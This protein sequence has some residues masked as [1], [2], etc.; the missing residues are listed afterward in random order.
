MRDRQSP[1][2]HRLNLAI[3]ATALI[4][5]I[6]T[7]P[8]RA[9]V[10][11]RLHFSVKNAADEKPLPKA[12]ILL[13]D[14][15]GVRPEVTLTTDDNGSVTSGP[16]D[17]R[18]WNV[19]TN[20]QKPDTFQSDTRSVTVAPDTTTEVEV[21][22][23]PIKEEKIIHIT[24]R[25]NI[26][27]PAQAN[28][29]AQLDQSRVNQFPVLGSN[30]QSLRNELLV[31]PGFVYDSANQAH[32]RGEH[33]STTI[34]L[35][36]FELPDV[37]MG[38]AGA[39]IL[40]EAL[41]N[42]DIMT[43]GFAPE[44]GG[45]SA[46]VLNLTLRAGTVTPFQQANFDVG[47]FAT[48]NGA[49]TFG[50][51][52]GRAIGK[53]DANGNVPRAF[54]YFL[55]INAR[56]TN[57]ALEPPQPD[58]QTAHNHAE[59]QAYFGNFSYQAS[60]NDELSLTVNS[61]PAYTQVANRSGL[62]SAYAPYG[63]GYGFGGERDASG[64]LASNLAGALAA[65][66][67]ATGT[68][69]T[70]IDVLP[71]QAQDG[72]DVWQRDVND[73]GVLSW[74]RKISP[75]VTSMVSASLIHS[76][77]SILNANGGNALLSPLNLPVDISVEVS[78]DIVRNYHHAQGQGS[79][80][81]AGGHHTVK[82]GLLYDNEEGDESYNLVSGS[83]LAL[84]ALASIDPVL[85][86]AGVPQVDSTGKPILDANGY[87]LFKATSNVTP[88]L[89]VH[90][91]GFYAAS[92]IQDTWTISKRFT[93]NYGL[94]LDWYKQN[95]N[96]PGQTGVDTADLSPRINL[97]YQVAKLTVLRGSFNRLFTQPP[98]AQGEV[99]GQAILPETLSQ[100]DVSL[101]RQL[102][103]NQKAKV[104][105]YVKDIRN[106]IDT[107]LLIPNTQFGAYTS[108]NFTTGN[109]H[110]FE[111]SWDLYP[112]KNVG[113]AAYLAYTNSVAKPGGTIDGVP[114]TQAPT[115]NDHDQLNTISTGASYTWKHGQNAALDF[116]YGSG[117]GSSGL[118]A[119][120]PLNTA[121]RTPNNHLNLSFTTGPGLFGGGAVD[122]HGGLTL[123]IEN[124]TN[125]LA[126][127]NFN[128]GFSGTRFEQG[129]RIMFTAFAKF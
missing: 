21:L 72:Q 39:L 27:S 65:N 129:R 3:L 118:S 79:L 121:P 48:Y 126:I 31:D 4:A 113:W 67:V 33:G 41:Q 62:S 94:R 51:Q 105:Y 102:A 101:E 111:L 106:Q 96:V 9:D 43:G 59:S 36:G 29:V 109:V 108:V 63:Q 84:D 30:P 88:T 73:F 70:G 78:P 23:E 98:L 124:V 61:A 11:G 17:A 87:Q 83:Q 74:R 54:G 19:T 14:S 104:A 16:L 53:P 97:A 107:G 8:A 91:S 128:S 89:S 82:G 25:K 81:Y 12:G 22:L 110:G 40:P 44:Y 15:A 115:Y 18:A 10:V 117:N 116:Y 46:A 75:Q 119:F 99:V 114:G 92:Y 20:A 103:P 100:Y 64:A 95:Q 1:I 34:F 69:G 127:I 52:A 57:N 123:L 56:A 71:T 55:D 2:P 38:R 112:K 120:N 49:L 68:F 45:E 26:V 42:V 93:A 60:S 58:D 76:G 47:E 24:A 85:A 35:N 80:T 13:K 37:L 66:G 86:P 90:R 125:N 50:G 28:A 32:P 5:S 122:G 6:L 77:Q 7:A